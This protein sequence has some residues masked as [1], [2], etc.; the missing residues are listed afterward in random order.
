[1]DV[2][3]DFFMGYL[4]IYGNMRCRML[5]MLEDFMALRGIKYARLDGSTNRVRRALDIKLVGSF[6]PLPEVS[7][8]YSCT[9]S[10][11]KSRVSQSPPLYL[12]TER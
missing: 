6:S 8:I 1:M 4:E 11:R 10:N 7:L 9:S 12:S 3:C 2:V 5:D